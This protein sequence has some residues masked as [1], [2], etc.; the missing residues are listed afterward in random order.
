[1]HAVTE[2]ARMEGEH[3]LALSGLV[4]LLKQLTKTVTD[5]VLN[6]EVTEDLGH[7]KNDPSRRASGKIVTALRYFFPHVNHSDY[8][9]KCCYGYFNCGTSFRCQW[10]GNHGNLE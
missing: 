7:E 4:G 2:L 6:G 3:G 8:L 10:G 9:A 5:T 1:M